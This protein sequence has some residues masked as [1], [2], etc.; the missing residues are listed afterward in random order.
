MN[1]GYS[2]TISKSLPLD[3][4]SEVMVRVEVIKKGT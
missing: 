3:Q 1:V 2:Y 4:N